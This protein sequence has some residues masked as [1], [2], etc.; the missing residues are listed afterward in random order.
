MH[1]QTDAAKTR[2]WKGIVLGWVP[3]LLFIAPALMN[4]LQGILSAKA[5]GMGAVAGGLTQGFTVFGLAAFVVCEVAAIFLLA[6]TLSKEYKLRSL[7]SVVSMCV[8]ALMLVGIGLVL[9]QL[10]AHVR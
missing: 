4:A 5:T 7:L 8:S 10:L 2:F 3:L 1:A 9:G 6:R